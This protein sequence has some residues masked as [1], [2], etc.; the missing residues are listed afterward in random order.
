MK[1]DSMS[2]EDE[3]GTGGRD[4]SKVLPAEEDIEEFERRRGLRKG[5]GGAHFLTELRNSG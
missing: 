1:Q 2:D 4:S 3:S 5:T